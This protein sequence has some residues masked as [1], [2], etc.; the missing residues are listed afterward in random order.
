VVVLERRTC[1]TVRACFDVLQDVYKA[2]VL[3]DSRKLRGRTNMRGELDGSTN[4]Q[5]ES[6]LPDL[7]TVGSQVLCLTPEYIS[8]VFLPASS[9]PVASPCLHDALEVGYEARYALLEAFA[10]LAWFR[11]KGPTPDEKAAMFYGRFYTSAAASC[12][13]AAAEDVANAI[14]N[15][16]ELDPAQ[17]KLESEKKTSLQSKVGKYLL[18][19]LPADPLTKAVVALNDSA[20]WRE[21]RQYRDGWVHE[22]VSVQGPGIVYERRKRWIVG[23]RGGQVL[24]VGVSGDKPKHTVD[25]V[26]GF[27]TQA[28]SEFFRLFEEVVKR[29]LDILSKA[30]ITLSQQ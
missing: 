29:Y 5:I 19:N 9:V 15:M 14:V 4:A 26:L 21:T 6:R 17:I 13:Y 23:A 7:T 25:D 18:K 30:G 1:G 10:H 22:Q 12:L 28:F 2:S 16:L 8:Q 20:A 27:V 11:D 3:M 24:R